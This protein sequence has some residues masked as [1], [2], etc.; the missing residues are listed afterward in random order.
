MTPL[1]AKRTLVK[2]APELWAELSEPEVLARH[3]AAFGEVRITS[4]E[5]ETTV[6]WEGE[7]ASGTVVLE[8][9]S[10]GTKVTL[11]AETEELEVLDTPPATPEPG[12]VPAPIDEV[13]PPPDEPEPDVEPELDPDPDTEEDAEPEPAPGS[14]LSQ[15]GPAPLLSAPRRRGLLSRLLSRRPAAEVR[16]VQPPPPWTFQAY[17]P[18]PEPEP[19]PEAAPAASALCAPIEPLRP[20]PIDP[21]PG[22]DADTAEFELP[23]DFPGMAGVEPTVRDL[24][25]EPGPPAQADPLPREATLAVLAGVLDTLGAAHHRPFSRG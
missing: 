24:R 17:E 4:L 7:R 9:S 6:A 23:W 15:A 10:W 22:G 21:E 16:M 8:P 5:P 3:L 1:R 25:L 11:V 18:E 19:E 14:P 20:A 13:A 12:L 2:S